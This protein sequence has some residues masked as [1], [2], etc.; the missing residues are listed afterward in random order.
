M[1]SSF[2]LRTTTPLARQGAF[3]S[4]RFFSSASN[5]ETI[6]FVGL[7]NMGFHQ[8]HNLTKKGY[9]VVAFDLNADAVNKLKSLSP[10]A[11]SAA[12]VRELTAQSDVVVTML[13]SSPHVKKVYTGP[14][15][16]F[17]GL[18]KG[19]NQLLI[20]TSTI[21]PGTTREVASQAQSRGATYIDAPVSGGTGGAEA[22]TLTFMVGG[23]KDAFNRA[24]PILQAMGKNIIHCGDVGAGQ[25]VKIC[26]NLVLG[27]S[28]VAISE[29]MNMGVRLGVDPKILA[30]VIN[31]SSGRCWSSDTYNP[32]PGVMENV[33]ASRGY[34]GGFM[35]DLM[36]KDLGLAVDAAKASGTPL[37][38]GEL[39]QSI[40][41]QLTKH[42]FG[43]KDF[44]SVY[45]YLQEIA[46]KD[47]K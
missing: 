33:P 19:G 6:G 26:N 13:P 45:L 23:S 14:D 15:G 7:G 38:L 37:Q 16:V 32:V 3:V 17:E 41:E 21:D 24:D 36:K 46:S 8:A 22:G 42:G 30:S 29:A 43:S 4:V 35:S 11:R 47:K 39:A 2:G 9:N 18:K 44:S 20:D 5:K 28:M 12:T 40:Y 1:L 27:I 31:R 10:N 25:V 34:T